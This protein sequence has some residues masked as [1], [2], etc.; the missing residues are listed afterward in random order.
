MKG[1]NL[2]IFE[3]SPACTAKATPGKLSLAGWLC[4]HLVT[5]VCI[6]RWL[7]SHTPSLAQ[8]DK[9]KEILQKPCPNHKFYWL[10]Q[11]EQIWRW[12]KRRE[13]DIS[14][15]PNNKYLR[16]QWFLERTAK[17]SLLFHGFCPADIKRYLLHQHPQQYKVFGD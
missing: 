17:P 1:L 12:C 6:S 15:M 10:F 2:D 16:K 8:T 5:F 13:V 11:H 14:S 3:V 7:L 4:R 9:D